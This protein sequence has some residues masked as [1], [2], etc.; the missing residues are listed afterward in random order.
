[1][2]QGTK[3]LMN[4][5]RCC[6]GMGKTIQAIS[7]IV[8]HRSDDFAPLQRSAAVAPTQRQQQA[9]PRPKLR[10]GA[11]PPKQEQ[12]QHSHDHGA[13]CCGL[14]PATEAL[15]GADAC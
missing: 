2:P 12:Q 11:A 3:G 1:M 8:T 15:A 9:A 6:A 7:L 5:A 14:L 13:A 10:L 4:T